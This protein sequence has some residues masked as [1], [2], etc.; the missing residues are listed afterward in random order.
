[1]AMYLEDPLALRSLSSWPQ[2]MARLL[3]DLLFLMEP[4]ELPVAAR[5]FWS[6][7][8]CAP[9]SSAGFYCAYNWNQ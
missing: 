7:F 5:V 3:Y 1:M 8:D 6:A 9:G 4:Y 2:G